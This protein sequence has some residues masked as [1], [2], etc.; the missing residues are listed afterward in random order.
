MGVLKERRDPAQ[1]VAAAAPSMQKD[2][3]LGCRLSTDFVDQAGSAVLEALDADEST[4]QGEGRSVSRGSRI[5]APPVRVSA[6]AN[7]THVRVDFARTRADDRPAEA[8]LEVLQDAP[9]FSGPIA[10]RRVHDGASER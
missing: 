1:A 3:V 7:G 10:R 2:Q 5:D 9:P 6:T 4:S 8:S